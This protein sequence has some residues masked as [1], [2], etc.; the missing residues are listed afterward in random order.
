MSEHSRTSNAAGKPGDIGRPCT[1]EEF[2]EAFFKL[3]VKER[4]P[5]TIVDNPFFQKDDHYCK[6]LCY[7][8]L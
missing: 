4:L 5:Y 1:Q 2:E 3:A 7:D 8:P 6:F